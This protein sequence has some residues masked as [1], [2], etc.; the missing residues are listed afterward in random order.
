MVIMTT[1]ARYLAVPKQLSCP[2]LC[3]VFIE[4]DHYGVETAV[5]K[6]WTVDGGVYP[7]AEA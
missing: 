6:A 7:V 2:A 1:K 5:A 3:P 4:K